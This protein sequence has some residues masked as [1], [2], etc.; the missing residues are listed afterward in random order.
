MSFLSIVNRVLHIKLFRGGLLSLL[1]RI[2]DWDHERAIKLFVN[3]GSVGR[4]LFLGKV[5]RVTQA[6]ESARVAAK[7]IQNMFRVVR[8]DN[9]GHLSTPCIPENVSE[10]D[11]GDDHRACL[12]T[13]PRYIPSIGL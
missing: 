11:R 9:F 5:C 8:P 4:H 13:M 10:N 6:G 7:G 1:L 3:R 2:H 12:F